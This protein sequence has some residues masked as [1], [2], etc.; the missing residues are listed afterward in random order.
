MSGG[1]GW[2][3]QVGRPYNQLAVLEVLVSLQIVVMP[4]P[5]LEERLTAVDSIIAVVIVGGELRRRDVAGELVH[6][7]LQ[8][9]RYDVVQGPG[10]GDL[11]D[12]PTPERLPRAAVRDHQ[13]ATRLPLL[14][15]VLVVERIAGLQ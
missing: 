3:K 4:G 1:R 13:I 15:V 12:G 14:T 10:R 8:L 6:L 2:R 11:L 9:D 5:V 7:A